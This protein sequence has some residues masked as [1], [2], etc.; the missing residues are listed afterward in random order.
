MSTPV[1]ISLRVTLSI[2]PRRFPRRFNP[3]EPIITYLKLVVYRSIMPC[4]IVSKDISSIIPTK[5]MLSTIEMDATISIAKFQD[6]ALSP[7][8]RAKSLSNTLY[9]IGR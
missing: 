9:S 3:I 5:R 7:L 1:G 6:R 4:G 8:E 2:N